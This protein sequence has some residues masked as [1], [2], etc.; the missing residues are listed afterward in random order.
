MK[1]QFCSF[2]RSIRCVPVQ[3]FHNVRQ[4]GGIDFLG[5]VD[6]GF[7]AGNKIIDPLTVHDIIRK[8]VARLITEGSGR[9]A[10][11]IMPGAPVEG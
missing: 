9:L 8:I 5:P 2:G 4:L 6:K 10:D 1:S 7:F 3:R 11:E